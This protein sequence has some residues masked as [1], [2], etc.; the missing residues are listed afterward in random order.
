M[1]SI[2]A[3]AF[4]NVHI[5]TREMPFAISNSSEAIPAIITT[6]TINSMNKIVPA[7]F[8]QKKACPCDAI[9]NVSIKREMQKMINQPNNFLNIVS[10]PFFFIDVFNIC[11][12]KSRGD[13]LHQ[14]VN[15]GIKAINK[16]NYSIPYFT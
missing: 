8:I 11:K 14:S 4:I 3:I 10:P 15:K 9:P 16:S 1:N 12:T 7:I 13:F 5:I 2:I 6:A